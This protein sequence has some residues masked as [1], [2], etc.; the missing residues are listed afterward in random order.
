MR[1]IK[2]KSEGVIPYNKMSQADVVNSML[3]QMHYA[4]DLGNTWSAYI[5]ADNILRLNAP[6][7]VENRLEGKGSSVEYT[8]AMSEILRRLEDD[9]IKI[10]RRAHKVSNS[11]VD[12]QIRARGDFNEERN[13]ILFVMGHEVMKQLE[14]LVAAQNARGVKVTSHE[15]AQEGLD[16][17]VPEDALGEFPEPSPSEEVSDDNALTQTDP[18]APAEFAGLTAEQ[19]ILNTFRSGEVDGRD[20]RDT[21]TESYRQASAITLPEGNQVSQELYES[22][23]KQSSFLRKFFNRDARTSAAGGPAKLSSRPAVKLAKLLVAAGVF[24]SAMVTYDSYGPVSYSNTVP[25]TQDHKQVSAEFS[26][27]DSG[28]VILD[29]VFNVRIDGYAKEATATPKAGPKKPSGGSVSEADAVSQMY[30]GKSFSEVEGGWTGGPTGEFIEAA[31][32]SL[33]RY[34]GE[35]VGKSEPGYANEIVD[36]VVVPYYYD[37]IRGDSGKTRDVVSW[38]PDIKNPNVSQITMSKDYLAVRDVDGKV[39]FVQADGPDGPKIIL[40]ELR[41]TKSDPTLEKKSPYGLQNPT[42][43][44]FS[45]PRQ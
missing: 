44:G 14:P 20:Y 19:M 25:D 42:V 41:Q 28:N 8:T 22:L 35:S 40:N 32:Y 15:G 10:Y 31:R 26:I 4:N 29:G 21:L 37:T 24:T 36:K 38:S 3:T 11:V 16:R 13:R 12:S 18:D 5:V 7:I 39:L 6:D 9:I 17:Y 45:M 2:K 30:S 43:Y 34:Y 27:R 1:I 23:K 33:S